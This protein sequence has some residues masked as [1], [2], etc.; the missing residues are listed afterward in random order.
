[1]TDQTAQQLRQ[2]IAELVGRYA[3]LELTAPSF[4]P[5]QHAVPPSGKVIGAPELQAMT[6]AVLDGWLTT[7]RFN[8]AFEKRLARY[9]GRRG[10]LTA[11]SGSSANL[12]AFS[13]LTSPRLGD[14]AIMKGD[15]V[16]GVAAGFPT[17]VN[18]I[19][20]F[21]AVPVFVDI[22]MGTYNINPDLIEAAIGPR[23]KAI[24]LAHTLGNPFNLKVVRELCD[25]YGLWL[26]EDCC[27]ALGA[28]Y[29]GRQVGS[30]G[31]LG[32]LSFY[33]AHHITMGEGGAVFTDSPL[34]KRIVESFR[35]WG[36]DCYCGPGED[37]TCHK[38]FCWQLGDLPQGYDHKYTYSH[39]GY[40]LKITDMQAACALAQMDRV[41][42]FIAA[43]KRNFAWLSDRLA[44]CTEQLI[45][46]HA[47][48]GS[49]PSWFGFPLTLRDGCGVER[50]NLLRH[51]DAQ[52]VG[53]R[54]LFAGNLT[55][56]PYMK[57]Q[58]YRVASDLSVTDKVM[59]DTFWIGLWPGLGEAHLEH[60]AS[61]IESYVR[62]LR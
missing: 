44:G 3:E 19:L 41:D 45:L 33:P 36:R 25:R 10:V 2:Q 28:T 13:A 5:G 50:L 53:T 54:L 40:N 23:T 31:D 12:L 32:T 14:R 48:P 24:M 22:E 17:T 26:I 20:Q 21:G 46:P 9:L 47:T 35:D 52:N 16:I 29:D 49:D 51:L 7:G 56:Q 55:R 15:E 6:E 30:F 57:D 11:N 42:D 8:Q 34:L 38:R 4:V 1:M 61:S 37:N 27:D 39:L 62:R 43:R 59:K 60:A 18:P 58:Q